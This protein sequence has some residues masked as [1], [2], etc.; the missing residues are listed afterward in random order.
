[1][2]SRR[3]KTGARS[4]VGLPWQFSAGLA[5]A[6]FVGIRWLLP[7]FLPDKG[8]LSAIA[9]TVAPLSWIALCAFGVL[10]LA[11]WVR[12][13]LQRGG[14][15]AIPAGRRDAALGSPAR[16]PPVPRQWSLEA[17]RSLEWKRFELLCARYYEAVGFGTA[18][19][20]AGADGG[21][22]VKLF[23]AD[24]STPLA[25]VQCKAWNSHSVGVREIR[26][27]LGVMVHEKVARGIFIT[28]GSYSADALAFGAANPIQLLD[29]PA[30]LGKVLDLPPDKQAALLAFAFEGDF[31]SPT[32]ASCGVKMVARESRRGAFWGCVHYPR[33]RTTLPM[34]HDSGVAAAEAA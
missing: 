10:A 32:C 26:E 13:R 29:G 6:S 33:C 9:S 24:P 28:S 4:L 30:F 16:R 11:A 12:S 21:I 5:V 17:L 1:M 7:A 20:A 8:P 25:I 19:L 15:G 3:R 14:A 34:R 27:L 18:T 22:D 31:H 23:R 2:S